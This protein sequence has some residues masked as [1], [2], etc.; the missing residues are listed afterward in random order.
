MLRIPLKVQFSDGREQTVVV[1]APDCIAFERHFDK[2]MTEITT[3]R[4]EYLWWV[5]WHALRR[6][7]KATLESFDEWVDSVGMISDD[8]E[9]SADFVPLESSQP[10]G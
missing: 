9:T 4:M 2:P 8:S 10:T 1:S 6:A 5:T 7:D 3:G